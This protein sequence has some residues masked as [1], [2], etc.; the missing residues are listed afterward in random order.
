MP[1]AEGERLRTLSQ[2]E[3]NAWVTH[4]AELAGDFVTEDRV[5]SDG[6]IY[7]AF[8]REDVSPRP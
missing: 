1:A 7:R 2:P 8:W 5:G 4:Y 3:I 6:V